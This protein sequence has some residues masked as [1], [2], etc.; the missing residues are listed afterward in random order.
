MSLFSGGPWLWLSPKLAHDLG[1][2]GL[3][4]WAKFLPEKNYEWR[5][6]DWRG[7]H[8]TNSLCIAGRID[9]TR[10]H[11]LDWYKFGCGFL[12]VGTVTPLAQEPN[13]GLIL[14][15]DLV[16]GAVWNKMGFPGPGATK[17]AEKLKSLGDQCPRPL[18]INIGKNRQTPNEKASE[19]YVRCFE[20]LYPFADAFVVNISSPNTTGLRALSGR[21]YL[22]NLLSDLALAQTRLQTQIPI[23]LKLSPDMTEAELEDV[24]ESSLK[25]NIDGWILTNTTLARTLDSKFS[26]EGGVSGRPLSE[27]SKLRL[28][29]AVKYLGVRKQDRLLISVGGVMR[30][31]DVFERLSMGADLVQV[32]STLIFEGPQFFG[33]TAKYFDKTSRD[34]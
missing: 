23:L 13:P 32:Y 33:H 12:E 22:E 8:F 14:D 10:A 5:S 30:P 15:R 26:K 27:T 16:S 28:E 2:L 9:K 20:R 17:L 24:L 31:E 34:H 4:L 7:F 1:P 3:N 21:E 6:L 29:Q 25:K 18:F 19:D 11:L